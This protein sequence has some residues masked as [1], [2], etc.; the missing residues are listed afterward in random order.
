MLNPADTR[1]PGWSPLFESDC[2]GGFE[3]L[4][5]A[6]IPSWADAAGRFRALAARQLF[7]GAA[8][9]LRREGIAANGALLDV[10]LAAPPAALARGLEGTAAQPIIDR[11]DPAIIHSVR[12]LLSAVLAPLRFL[13]DEG[14]PFSIREWVAREDGAGWLFLARPGDPD[15]RLKGL[16]S[17]WAEIALAALSARDP[18]IGMDRV[19]RLLA[20]LDDP[21]ALHRLPGLLPTLTDARRLGVRFMIGIEAIGPLRALY[22]KDGAATIS[23]LCGTRVAMMA[24]DEETAEWSSENLG[25]GSGTAAWPW[26][27]QRL[28]RGHGHVRFPGGH[29]AAKFV[30]KDKQR[31]AAGT[32]FMPADGA[33]TFLAEPPAEAAPDAPAGQRANPTESQAQPNPELDRKKSRRQAT[34]K[35][36]SRQGPN[37]A[38]KP[39]PAARNSADTPLDAGAGAS[40]IAIADKGDGNAGTAAPVERDQRKRKYARW[41]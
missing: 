15:G 16:V 21:A 6:L 35:A 25:D 19:R 7:A 40:A 9:V 1:C 8:E 26:E 32:P 31:R 37:P 30:I 18:E 20:V 24:A 4:A 33:K 10:L 5:E 11:T 12:A 34:R 2:R 36:V 39:A 3:A 27:I 17:S 14:A 38:P 23:G 28:P 22:G 41:I 29:P 13:P